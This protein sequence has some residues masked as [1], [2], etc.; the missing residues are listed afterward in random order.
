MTILWSLNK[1]KSQPRKLSTLSICI[2]WSYHYKKVSLFVILKLLN[3]LFYSN[4]GYLYDPASS[5]NDK[6]RNTCTDFMWLICCWSWFVDSQPFHP[7]WTMKLR[8]TNLQSNNSKMAA[9]LFF[10]AHVMIS[11]DNYYC[12]YFFKAFLVI[13]NVSGDE[14]TYICSKQ[15]S[16]ISICGQ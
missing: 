7:W 4:Y 10:S 16:R 11:A 1:Q 8:L 15:T 3:D 6:T 5:P 9:I 2:V 13:N 12:Y 14:W